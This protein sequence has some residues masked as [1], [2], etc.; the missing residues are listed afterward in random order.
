MPGP[1]HHPRA[2]RGWVP[3]LWAASQRSESCARLITGKLRPG[4]AMG[5]PRAPGVC[6]PLALRGQGLV[7]GVLCCEA[8]RRPCTMTPVS[9][10]APRTL[11][12]SQLQRSFA[13]TA[14]SSQLLALL[15]GEAPLPSAGWSCRWMPGHRGHPSPVLC[16]T[17]RLLSGL[18]LWFWDETAKAARACFSSS[19]ILGRFLVP[20]PKCHVSTCLLSRCLTGEAA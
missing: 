19:P 15:R 13:E 1:P 3:C 2:A 18:R 11:P 9:A 4:L 5:T 8:E 6:D 12:S 14:K 17:E 20:V 16:L 10:L 7:Q